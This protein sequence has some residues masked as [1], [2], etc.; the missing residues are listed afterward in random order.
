MTEQIG[1]TETEREALRSR[2]ASWFGDERQAFLA[3]HLAPAVERIVADRLVEQRDE[4]TQQHPFRRAAELAERLAALFAVEE[5]R[6]RASSGPLYSQAVVDELRVDRE[7]AEREQS[8]ALADVMMWQERYAELAERMTALVNEAE[9]VG[10]RGTCPVQPCDC[11]WSH[12]L[13]DAVNA[14]TGALGA[15]E[16]NAMGIKHEP[17]IWDFGSDEEFSCP[18]DPDGLEPPKAER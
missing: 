3:S 8:Q 14:A 13:Y 5:S 10:H 7:V 2:L 11:W 9:K 4:L 16:C 15:M 6:G 17:H 18:G 12:G 1:L